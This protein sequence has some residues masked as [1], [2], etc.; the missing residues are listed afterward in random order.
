MRVLNERRWPVFSDAIEALERAR[1]E[2][3]DFAT[4]RTCILRHLGRLCGVLIHDVLLD[5]AFDT[6]GRRA[7]RLP[8]LR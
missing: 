8:P 7:C 1:Q 6:L 4:R 5:R 3:H 2:F